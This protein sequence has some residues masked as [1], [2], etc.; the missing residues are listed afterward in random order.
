[1]ASLV[2]PPTLFQSAAATLN[3]TNAPATRDTQ[4]IY[5]VA[6]QNVRQKPKHQNLEQ[7]LVHRITNARTLEEL[8]QIAGTEISRDRSLRAVALR[9]KV[10]AGVNTF[11]QFRELFDLYAQAGKVE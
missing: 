2:T 11:G 7:D 6:V 3:S 1:M 5:K 10:E 8:A 9:K 4:E